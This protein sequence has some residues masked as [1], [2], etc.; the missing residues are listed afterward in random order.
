VANCTENDSSLAKTRWTQDSID[1]L[2]M[3]AAETESKFKKLQ[4]LLQLE[5]ESLESVLCLIRND[6]IVTLMLDNPDFKAAVMSVMT[7]NA[8]VVISRA[9][10]RIRTISK[11]AL[12]E[13]TNRILK[14]ANDLDQ[15]GELRLSQL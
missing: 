3:D 5:D 1:R 7:A 10:S 12:I 14:V 6:E 9:L 15:K 4:D 11:D 2:S 13:A 8:N